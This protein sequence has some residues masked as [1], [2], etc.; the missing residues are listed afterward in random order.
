MWH[1]NIHIFLNIPW[2]FS[3][4]Q[5]WQNVIACGARRCCHGCGFTL[6][7]P[8]VLLWP[9]S[10][11]PHERFG[12][13]CKRWRQT[14]PRQQLYVCVVFGVINN[15][16]PFNSTENVLQHQ[17]HNINYQLLLQCPPCCDESADHWFSYLSCFAVVAHEPAEVKR[18]E[19]KLIL[20]FTHLWKYTQ[21]SLSIFH[22]WHSTL[23]FKR[24]T[25]INGR[26]FRRK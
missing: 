21:S 3:I 8:I 20:T 11:M 13:V 5:L 15:P 4:V 19:I 26:L 10:L 22:I 9:Q 24:E 6:A 16:S 7:W 1:F 12:T 2:A 25:F 23:W 17:L 14:Q 18:L